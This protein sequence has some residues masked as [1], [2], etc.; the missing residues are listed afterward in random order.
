MIF[1]ISS[2]SKSISNEAVSEEEV[3]SVCSAV[4]RLYLCV[5]AALHRRLLSPDEFIS[6]TL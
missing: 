5:T 2:L 4:V 1:M 3:G 6:K